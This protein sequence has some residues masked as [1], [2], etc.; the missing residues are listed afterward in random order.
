MFVRLGNVGKI[1]I[2]GGGDQLLVVEQSAELGNGLVTDPLQAVEFDSHPLDLIPHSARAFQPGKQSRHGV[3]YHP[4]SSLRI[5]AFLIIII[6]AS[7]FL[8]VPRHSYSCLVITSPCRPPLAPATC[9][10]RCYRRPSR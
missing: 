3:A 9:A 10:A 1:E 8:F 7:S 2:G 4:Y 5:T 6:R